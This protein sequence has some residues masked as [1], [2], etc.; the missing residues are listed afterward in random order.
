[1]PQPGEVGEEEVEVALL[2]TM[3]MEEED[4]PM[5]RAQGGSES[6]SQRRPYEAQT[7]SPLGSYGP[8]Q[9]SPGQRVEEVEEVEVALLC[10]MMEEEDPPM[11]R[12]QGGSE[13][14]SQERP[15]EA[16][17]SSPL[18]SYGPLQRSPGQE[19]EE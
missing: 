8:E 3:M 13:S 7:L 9:R 17:I 11:Q 5:Q 10:T 12:A 6:S 18:G 14:S 4:P 19:E 15:I 1:M 2:C 16:Q